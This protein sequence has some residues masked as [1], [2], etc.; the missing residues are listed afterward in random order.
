[1]I[2]GRCILVKKS[3][4]LTNYP[5]YLDLLEN[6]KYCKFFNLREYLIPRFHWFVSNSEI[7]NIKIGI[8]KHQFL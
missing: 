3:G 5:S 4:W 6:F 1:M 7:T 8:K 2:K